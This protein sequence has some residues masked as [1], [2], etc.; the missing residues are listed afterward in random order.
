MAD[1]E[2]EDRLQRFRPE[3]PSEEARARA[4]DAA[5]E[6]RLRTFRPEAAS[7]ALGEAVLAR[8]AADAATRR[9]RARAWQAAAAL[10]IVASV[11]LN[12]W[13]EGSANGSKAPASQGRAIVA[14]IPRS[15]FTAPRLPRVISAVLRAAAEWRELQGLLSG[16]ADAR[17]F[18][19]AAKEGRARG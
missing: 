16:S 3:P 18:G 7:A 15:S 17:V 13:I 9:R 8:V 6:G 2:F 11:P 10:L 5:F 4:L 19:G 14:E 1:R 12:G